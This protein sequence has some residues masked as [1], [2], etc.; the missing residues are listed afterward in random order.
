M[1]KKIAVTGGLA[2]GKTTV[3]QILHTFGAKVV[4]ADEMVHELLRSE[5]R[6][7]LEAEFGK[8]LMKQD[9]IDRKIL[10]EIV[11]NNPE[12]L[13]KLEALIHP[14]L[15]QKIKEEYRSA[16]G[17]CFVV[18]IPLLYEIGAEDFYDIVI[19]VVTD[20]EIAKRRFQGSCLDYDLRMKRQLAPIEKGKRA[21]YIL[22]NNG[23]L[24]ELERNTLQL[25]K[26]IYPFQMK[27]N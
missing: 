2:S 6:E 11:F 10:A 25:W 18:E 3:C 1:L 12:K 27:E 15:L 16:Q 21:D 24:E 22:Y 4:C 14:K 19:A 7:K 17:A 20:E 13:K 23:T 8:E 9:Q 26:R 5:L